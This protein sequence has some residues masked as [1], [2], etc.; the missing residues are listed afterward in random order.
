LAISSPE[1]AISV[2]ESLKEIGEEWDQ[3]IQDFRDSRDIEEGE[4]GL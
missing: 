4:L 1:D 3:T 2:L